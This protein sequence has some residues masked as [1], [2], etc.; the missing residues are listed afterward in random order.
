MEPL[1]G[2]G[3]I[4]GPLILFLLTCAFVSWLFSEPKLGIDFP[5]GEWEPVG[6]DDE[7][8]LNKWSSRIQVHSVG[9]PVCQ[10]CRVRLI[11]VDELTADNE[12]VRLDILPGGA[13]L[14]WSRPDLPEVVDISSKSPGIV[15]LYSM[16]DDCILVPSAEN[17]GAPHMLDCG[18]KYYGF[19]IE[20]TSKN[21]P[22][23]T[24][25]V[26]VHCAEKRKRPV[27]YLHP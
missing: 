7:P 16:G 18:D 17:H 27:M 10:E 4:V 15:E 22:P 5:D 24:K 9:R 21:A 11:K 13:N 20:A 12:M 25:Y 26:N 8:D 19:E 6:C 1:A 23:V 2:P 14:R 3:L